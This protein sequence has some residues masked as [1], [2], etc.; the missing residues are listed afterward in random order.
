MSIYRIDRL[1]RNGGLV[2][3][4]FYTNFTSFYKIETLN[5]Q[6]LQCCYL[7]FESNFLFFNAL[8][9]VSG[10][11]SRSKRTTSQFAEESLPLQ[12]WCN[13]C[14]ASPGRKPLKTKPYKAFK[15]ATIPQI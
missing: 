12:L 14:C 15:T 1:N 2:F 7:G 13:R 9:W 11:M 6:I 3:Y 10:V 4:D 8:F 5:L